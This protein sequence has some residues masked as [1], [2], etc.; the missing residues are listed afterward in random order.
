MAE[1]KPPLKPDAQNALVGDLESI[2]NLLE[3]D[4]DEN[5]KVDDGDDELNIP[6]LDDVVATSTP[7]ST[8]VGRR[9]PEL[10]QDS[11]KMAS[12]AFIAHARALLM[13][14]GLGAHLTEVQSALIDALVD[15]LKI[16]VDQE[17]EH[18]RTELHLRLQA[19][20][21]HIKSELSE[22]ED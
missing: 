20:L 5:Q 3:S 19:E 18:I 13:T 4:D 15:T 1:K 2:K 7:K 6:V 16:A 10:T 22:D 14:K 12:D 9:G 8:A 21:D 11:W 17:V